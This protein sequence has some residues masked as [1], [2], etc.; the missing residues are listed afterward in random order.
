MN[1]CFWRENLLVR[2]TSDTVALSPPLI[3]SEEQ[4]AE[5]VA[6]VRRA[7]RFTN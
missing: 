2:V 7:I 4:I 1:A 5:I 3:I 6:G